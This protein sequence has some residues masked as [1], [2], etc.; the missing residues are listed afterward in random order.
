MGVARP[1]LTFLTAIRNSPPFFVRPI[2][3]LVASQVENQFLTRNI[4]SNLAF[5]E[6]Q[7]RTSPEGGQFICGKEL[8]VADILMSFPVIAVNGRMLKD[9]KNRAKYPLLVGYAKRLEGIEGYQRA[10]KKIEEIE[11]KFSASM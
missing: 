3:N 7:L 10:V 8:T 5:L 4:D 9:E 11:G 2:T 1:A 6:E